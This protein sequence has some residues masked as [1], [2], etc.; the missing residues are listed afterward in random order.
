MLLKPVSKTHIKEKIKL[1]H[2]ND[3]K[4]PILEFVDDPNVYACEVSASNYKSLESARGSVLSCL[5]RL[6]ISTIKTTVIDGVLYLY[7]EG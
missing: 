6:K 7:K 3:L 1:S 4:T 2:Y 5:K